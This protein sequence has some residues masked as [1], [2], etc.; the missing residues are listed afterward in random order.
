MEIRK[1][2][3]LEEKENRNS[4]YYTAPL[5]LQYGY[6]NTNN[7]PMSISAFFQ[8]CQLISTGIATLPIKVKKKSGKGKTTELKNHSV[9]LLFSN[10]NS[11]LS[12]YDLMKL[13]IQSVILR[14][15]GYCY[16]RRATDGTPIELQYLNS[17]DVIINYNKQTNKLTYTCSLVSSKPI[18]PK[19]MI[20]LK[21]N[22]YDGVNGVSILSYASRSLD[23]S[24][25][26]ENSASNYYKKGGNLSG[27]LKVN[28]NLSD[29]QRQQILN[30]WNTS[31][32]NNNSSI[33]VIQGNMEFTQLSQNA[34]ELQLLESR[35]FSV[36][37]VAR[38][39]SINPVLLG[40]KGVAT[41]STLEMV[42]NDFLLHT[43]QPYIS[44][45]EFEFSR[46]LL[47]ADEENLK[48]ILDTNSVLRTSKKEQAAYFS[49][50][51]KNGCI[52]VNEVRSELGYSQIEGGDK[53]IQAFTDIAQNTIADADSTG[54]KD[55]DN[56]EENK[57][58]ENG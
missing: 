28:A 27:L 22:S 34:E 46:K 39:M 54:S 56:N 50:L 12:K 51:V 40:L 18:E 55:N 5:S 16:I 17:D 1:F 6:Y 25:A 33:A 48:I 26:I 21:M 43:L 37:D 52:T 35:N 15:N 49:E 20:H 3:G 13:L 8:S 32:R 29:E 7:S 44:M 42:Q 45:V 31:F 57:D 11:L 53:L 47:N 14:G 9:N 24:S 19:D 41:Y 10:R 36:E 30:N 23:I 4:G 38:F 58:K 2:F